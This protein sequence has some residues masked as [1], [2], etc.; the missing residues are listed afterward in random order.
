MSSPQEASKVAPSRALASWAAPPWAISR[1][2]DEGSIEHRARVGEVRP[3][4]PDQAIVVDVVQRDEL[5]EDATSIA[6][7]PAHVSVSGILLETCRARDLS[8]QLL[9]AADIA[10]RGEKSGATTRAR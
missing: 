3:A 4:G 10:E 7:G 5:S 2:V 6:R 8:E 1:I 9:A